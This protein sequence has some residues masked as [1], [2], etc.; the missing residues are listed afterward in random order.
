MRKRR[1]PSSSSS[2]SAMAEVQ[3]LRTQQR[4]RTD[5]SRRRG[6]SAAS[7]QQRIAETDPLKLPDL[8]LSDGLRFVCR[9][10][11]STSNSN[12]SRQREKRPYRDEEIGR[13]NSS[14][15]P[16]KELSRHRRAV[17]EALKVLRDDIGN[18]ATLSLLLLSS[19]EK[20]N[21]CGKRLLR[22]NIL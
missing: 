4:R 22:R 14:R 16:R 9:G 12:G 6:R 2:F 21:F 7:P 20:K 8:K 1:K 19:S 11:N 10:N 18:A 5:L 17:Q 15:I 13:P 3:T